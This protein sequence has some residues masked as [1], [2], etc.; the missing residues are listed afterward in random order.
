MSKS[1]AK[2]Q[3]P[4]ELDQ[5]IGFCDEQRLI[6][7]RDFKEWVP[8]IWIFKDRRKWIIGFDPFEGNHRS[9]RLTP[10]GA[11]AANHIAELGDSVFNSACACLSSWYPAENTG[12][13]LFQLKPT[14][15]MQFATHSLAVAYRGSSRLLFLREE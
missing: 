7:F 8:W 10:L 6:P 14:S 13:I 15:Y 11:A 1:K 2:I 4:T 3:R 5:R 9:K 12:S